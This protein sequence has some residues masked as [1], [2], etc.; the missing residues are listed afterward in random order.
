MASKI[1]K[2]G[3]AVPM[4]VPVLNN[5]QLWRT[6]TQS[7]QRKEK[8]KDEVGDS[9]KEDTPSVK[10]WVQ[11]FPWST[12]KTQ[13]YPEEIA[14]ENEEEKDWLKAEIQKIDEEDAEI[15]RPG[16]ILIE[17]LLSILPVEQQEAVREKIRK[18]ETE[19]ARQ[20]QAKNI[21]K[22]RLAERDEKWKNELEIRWQLPPGQAVYLRKFNMNTFEAFKNVPDPTTRKNLWQ[23]YARCKAFLHSFIKHVPDRSWVILW[24]SQKA[25]MPGD[26]HWAEHLVELAEDML[27]VGK[28]LSINRRVLYLEALCGIGRQGLAV[29]KWQDW[30]DDL[31]QK[32]SE[33][34][35][36]LG[37]RL[38]ASQGDPEKAERIA[39]GALKGGVPEKSRILIPAI[40]AW[41]SR[42]DYVGATHAWAIYLRLKEHL[43]SRFTMGDY[44]TI[45]MIFLGANRAD[46]AMAVFKDMMLQDMMLNEYQADYGSV[47]LY[48]KSLS[49]IGKA[50]DSAVS[51]EDLKNVSLSRLTTMPNPFNNRFFY[52]KLLKK[53]MGAG[54][55]QAATAVIELMYKRGLQPAP[56]HVNGL[57]GAWIR[58]GTREDGQAAEEMAWAMV[59]ERY[60]LVKER[61]KNESMTRKDIR[62]GT[63]VG[64][65][66]GVSHDSRRAVPTAT[67]ETFC[68]LLQL[69]GR[70]SRY[71][72]VQL[73]QD[74]LEKAELKPNV[75]FVNHLLYINLRRGRYDKVWAEFRESFGVMTPDL[76][77]FAALWDTERVHL[78]QKEGISHD[79]FP[80]P[81]ILMSHMINWLGQTKPHE[82]KE[83]IEGFNKGLR[84]QI[85]RCM[86]LSDDR[87][88]IIVALYAMKESFGSY[89]DAN[90]V[91]MISANIRRMGIGEKEARKGG[92]AKRGEGIKR[93]RLQNKLKIADAFA[94]IVEDRK[95]E[96]R[97]HGINLDN[98][99][100]RIFRE[101]GL[102]V[103]SEFL[104]RIL[105][106][107][108]I[109]P[110]EVQGNLEKAAWEMGVGGIR[111][112]DPLL[113]GI[114][115]NN[116]Q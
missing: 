21:L 8:K 44:D 111:M 73:V 103:L 48:R 11:D 46:L 58:S 41:A 65:N 32:A 76:E 93:Q 10:W 14:Q 110:D 112:E 28:P 54:E 97:A 47:E 88:G 116:A 98:T 7:S 90:T 78:Y 34:H 38:F 53:L 72:N 82:R 114:Y 19:E 115:G 49:L 102:F 24:A 66:S 109:Y 69:Y 107:T 26:P 71:D 35:E 101:E 91:R 4:F 51:V 22:K 56:K 83:A 75:Y 106:R 80:G 31:D 95:W 12:T 27:E 100:E 105:K 5:S 87:E 61:R 62:E 20:I 1:F 15:E 39:F 64:S 57:I 55:L 43:G 30:S 81:R 37:V 84:D 40:T 17:P 16:K 94:L 70:S 113:R 13:I 104:R 63:V 9:G 77:T 33:A 74:A 25:G 79:P 18:D 29:E 6:F 50:Q 96:L 68:L 86:C 45:I 67:V 89:P 99:E 59:Y 3:L 42:G 108:A 92:R 36:L 85:I 2:I 23:S 52:G 60:D